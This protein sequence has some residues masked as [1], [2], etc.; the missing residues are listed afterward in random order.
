MAPVSVMPQ[1]WSAARH[2]ILRMR[3]ERCFGPQHTNT[4]HCPTVS[5]A[6]RAVVWFA[7]R[8]YLAL[9]HT[10][11]CVKSCGLVRG[12]PIPRLHH[13]LRCIKSCALVHGA[14]IPRATPQPQMRQELCFGPRRANTSHC[15]TVSDASRGV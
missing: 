12:S 7:A 14:P 4:L 5:D 13:S 3:Q 11:R 9:Y 15:S 8:Q 6:S 2:A 10:L 1:H